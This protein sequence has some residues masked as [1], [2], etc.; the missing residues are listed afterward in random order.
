MKKP[1]VAGLL[2]GVLLVGAFV[3]LFGRGKVFRDEEVG[4]WP[5]AKAVVQTRIFR[6]PLVKL[7]DTPAERYVGRGDV[8]RDR[9]LALMKERGFTYEEAESAPAEAA[10][11]DMVFRN[12]DK[13]CYGY[14]CPF[15]RALK[16][17]EVPFCVEDDEEAEAA[18]DGVPGE[19]DPHVGD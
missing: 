18:D 11:G 15:T 3:L 17:Y 19:E 10:Q 12:A 16:V 13:F 1:V 14:R 2:V 5:I 6:S 9:F 8:G 7:S 4:N